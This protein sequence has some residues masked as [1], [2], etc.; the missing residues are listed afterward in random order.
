MC[1]WSHTGYP[2]LTW[3]FVTY[4]HGIHAHAVAARLQLYPVILLVRVNLR[5]AILRVIGLI[6]CQIRSLLEIYRPVRIHPPVH[7]S[8][9]LRAWAFHHGV[10]VAGMLPSPIFR[11]IGLFRIQPVPLMICAVP[12]WIRFFRQHLSRYIYSSCMDHS[13]A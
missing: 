1:V 9:T 11:I 7:W 5:A 2:V 8:R 6:I 10:D 13:L 12:P 3:V 4:S